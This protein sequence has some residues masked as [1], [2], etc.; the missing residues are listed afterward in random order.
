MKKLLN[1]TE[2]DLGW[3][4]AKIPIVLIW[5][6]IMFYMILSVSHCLYPTGICRLYSFEAL[7][8]AGGKY[9]LYVLIT[10]CV[11]NYI[12]EKRMVLTT[13]SMFVISLIVIS[14]HE[15]NGIYFRA[16]V[17]SPLWGVQCLAYYQYKNNPSFDITYY[18]Q[19]YVWQIIAA[20]YTLAGIAKIYYSGLAWINAGPSFYLQVVKNHSFHY[21]D[22]GRLDNFNQILAYGN[23]LSSY[24]PVL[25]LLLAA[26]LFLEVG[27]F[28]VLI[29]K[30]IR[31]VW[32][33]GLL[34]MHIFI[35]TVMGI[36]ISVIAFPMIFFFLNPFYL[37]ILGFKKLIKKF[38]LIY[39]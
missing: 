11:I 10:W 18:R 39:K 16:T 29:N 9:C 15:S 30:K 38:R 24:L 21:F 34:L 17:L 8:T 37:I 36:G 32:G 13:F 22:S 4:C 28:L 33:M 6:Y 31:F 27:C 20:V 1:E 26:A 3:Y 2:F 19:Q 5:A 14:F 23:I 25:K 35:G 12:L 7:F